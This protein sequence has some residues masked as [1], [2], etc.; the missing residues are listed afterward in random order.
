MKITTSL[1]FVAIII[2]VS[3]QEKNNP[4]SIIGTWKLITGTLTEKNKTTVTHYDLGKSFIKI[5]NSTHFAFLQH[6]LN[7]GKDSSTAVFEAGG[8]AYTL[9]G[10]QYTEHLEYCSGRAWEGN[11]FS[12]TVEIKNDTLIQT[13]I[14][15][16]DS[17]GVDRLNV[18]KYIRVK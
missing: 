12:F 9:N 2:F 7:R 15:K 17:L 13:G 10:N 3:C 11:S 6:D 8:G 14:E 5:I 18:E 1:L 16:I 4:A